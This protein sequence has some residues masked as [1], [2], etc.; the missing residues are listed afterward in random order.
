MSEVD[1]GSDQIPV[2]GT[3]R[4]KLRNF[5]KARTSSKL[6]INMLLSDDKATTEEF[7]ISVK[8]GFSVLEQ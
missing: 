6:Q 7:C 8:I 3:R 4:L 1:F 5:E 2:V